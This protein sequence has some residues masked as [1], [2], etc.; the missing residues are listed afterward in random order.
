MHFRRPPERRRPGSNVPAAGGPPPSRGER[1][2]GTA[3]RPRPCDGSEPPPPES[4]GPG[5][6]RFEN[7]E[8][9]ISGGYSR[10]AGHGAGQRAT[11]AAS[12]PKDP[13]SP[14]RLVTVRVGRHQFR[15]LEVIAPLAEAVPGRVAFEVR[16]LD[17]LARGPGQAALDADVEK[18]VGPRRMRRAQQTARLCRTPR[19]SSRRQPT[20]AALKI[21][22]PA[23]Q[24]CV[25]RR[26]ALHI[27]HPARRRNEPLRLRVA[28]QQAV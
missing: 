9:S 19:R 15:R 20:G 2:R 25:D 6:R 4:G 11:A 5:V 24:E 8:S 3:T 17:G 28:G 26:L 21:P 13:T 18:A 16:N 1:R 22:Q 12:V 7:S 14:L 10:V 23:A 27:L